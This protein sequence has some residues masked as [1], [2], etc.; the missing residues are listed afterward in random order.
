MDADESNLRCDRSVVCSADWQQN[1]LRASA[2]IRGS[3]F[4]LSAVAVG[5]QW[6]DASRRRVG[7]AQ[8]DR[9]LIALDAKT[10][11]FFQN[12]T[13]QTE[14][15]VNIEVRVSDERAQACA[16]ESNAA[17][18]SERPLGSARLRASS[19]WDLPCGPAAAHRRRLKSRMSPFLSSVSTLTDDVPA[20]GIAPAIAGALFAATGIRLRSLPLAPNGIRGGRG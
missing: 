19:I 20:I 1:H 7:G 16:A 8:R 17:A 12:P 3:S 2:F 14:R 11:E 6:F 5:T 18:P 10:M 15:F 13:G 4:N 9:L